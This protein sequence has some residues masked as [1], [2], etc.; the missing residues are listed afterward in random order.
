MKRQNKP[1]APPFELA[2]SAAAQWANLQAEMP[3]GTFRG[4]LRT[5]HELW[6]AGLAAEHQAQFLSRHGLPAEL[7]EDLQRF[8]S[9]LGLSPL[10]VRGKRAA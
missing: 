3:T 4:V 8:R 1:L 10:P 6:R 2:R 5:T 7:L 9:E